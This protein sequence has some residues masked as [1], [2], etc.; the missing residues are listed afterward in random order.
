M[1]AIAEL[2]PHGRDAAGAAVDLPEKDALLGAVFA[3]DIGV[4]DPPLNTH[5]RGFLW[6]GVT[7]IDPAHDRTFDEVKD[8]G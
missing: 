8:E 2:D 4:D 7:K 3:S 1:K 5:D 6:F